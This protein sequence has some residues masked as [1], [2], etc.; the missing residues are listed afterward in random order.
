MGRPSALVRLIL[1]QAAPNRNIPEPFIFLDGTRLKIVD[2]FKYLGSSIPSDGSLDRG[3]AKQARHLEGFTLGCS[4]NTTSYSPQ[5]SRPTV[6]LLEHLS[7]VV[8][9][10]EHCTASALSS[11]SK[12]ISMLFVP[13]LASAGRTRS[14][15]L[16]SWIQPRQRALKQCFPR[17]SFVGQDVS[18]GWRN[19]ACHAHYFM[20][21]W[22]LG[23][24][25]EGAHASNSG[26]S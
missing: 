5:S 3:S 26:T 16:R 2:N 17:P 22:C 12:F 20:E 1:H 23:N 10:P 4:T 11:W 13:C 15:V 8:M 7:S 21:S 14:P 24:K 19:I 9:R 18:S 25:A 6:S